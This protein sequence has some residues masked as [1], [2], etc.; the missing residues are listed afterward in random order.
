MK[1]GAQNDSFYYVVKGLVEVI[2]EHQNFDYF[3]HKKVKRFMINH[4]NEKNQNLQTSKNGTNDSSLFAQ[5][6]ES[7]EKLPNEFM[8]S[9][10]ITRLKEETK[11]MNSEN[12]EIK[13]YS[14]SSHTQQD[15]K[16]TPRLGQS[17]Y[18]ES[19][20]GLLG[21]QREIKDVMKTRLG[22]IL[23][24]NF[25][26]EASNLDKELSIIKVKNDNGSTSACKKTDIHNSSIMENMKSDAHLNIISIST[27]IIKSVRT[28]H[29]NRTSGNGP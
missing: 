25:K 11:E 26:N 6:E 19:V 3:N 8:N 23:P 24:L 10:K 21:T 17:A 15:L 1:Q 2:F 16:N 22:K 29:G 27:K 9:F 14:G 28:Q 18:E 13:V 4:N 20:E 12:P 7:K 5:S